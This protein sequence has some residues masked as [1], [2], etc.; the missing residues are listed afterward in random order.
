MQA[1]FISDL[2]LTPERP[3]IAR[4]FLR[5]MDEQAPKSDALYILGDFFEYWVGDD[6]MEPFHRN[7]ADKLRQY[8]NAGHQLFFM[9]GNRDFAVGRQFL[10]RTGARW[11]NDPCTI[12]LNGEKILL[13][14][15]DLL[16][17]DDEQ[18][19][20]YRRRIRH[21]LVLGFLRLLPLS[22]RKKLG[23]RIRSNSKAA[24]T[25]KSLEIM[26]VNHDEV[27]RVMEQYQVKTLI[28]GHTHRPDTHTVPL[29]AGTGQRIVLGDWD[30]FGWVLPSDKGLLQERFSL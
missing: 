5:F 24:K 30:Q 17:T 28:H 10:K 29:S 14:H 26:D 22:Y 13:M 2:H 27:I 21:P 1:Q 18:Y 6:A 11:L 19:Q 4:A 12:E 23:A 16:C 9:P 8:T 3:D 20:K 25:G 7:I 15:G